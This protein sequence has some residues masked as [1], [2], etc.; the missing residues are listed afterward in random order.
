MADLEIGLMGIVLLV[1]FFALICHEGVLDYYYETK[2]RRNRRRPPPDF[3]FLQ[4]QDRMPVKD[5]D[6][7]KEGF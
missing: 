1:L 7:P 6:W 4:E 5:T 3:T 2:C